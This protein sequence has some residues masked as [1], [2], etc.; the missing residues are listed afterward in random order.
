MSDA[1]THALSGAQACWEGMRDAGLAAVVVCPGARS[2]PLAVAAVASVGLP[3]FVHADERAAAFFALGASRAAG[4]P[5]ALVTTSGS[6]VAHAMPALVE[7]DAQGVPLLLVSAD[8]PERLQGCGAPQ[9]MRQQG[10][11]S[12][13]LRAEAHLSVGQVDAA[14]SC[15]LRTRA[16]Q[17]A[18]MACAVPRRGP[19]HLNVSFDEPLLPPLVGSPPSAPVTAPASAWQRVGASTALDPMGLAAW[20]TLTEASRRP[21]VVLGPL[22]LQPEERAFAEAALDAGLAV[23][24]DPASELRGH[25]EALT[26]GDHVAAAS[27]AWRRNAP[28]LVVRCGGTLTSKALE[29]AIGAADCPV[30]ALDPSQRFTDPHRRPMT[31]FG[32]VPP[33]A[34]L[35]GW[36]VDE[37]Y[38]EG[39][40]ACDALVRALIAA[41]PAQGLLPEEAAWTL[42]WLQA[43]CPQ[44]IQV[45]SSM[46]I[47]W[48]ELLG[49]P[50]G[51]HV[52]V[53]SNRGLNGIDGTLASA[54]GWAWRD[55]KTTWVLL[56]DLAFLHDVGS[57]ELGR[58]C[59]GRLRVFVLNNDGGGIFHHLPFHGSSATFEAVFGTPHGLQAGPIAQ[60]FG[61]HAETVT[62]R[63]DMEAVCRRLE[64]LPGPALIEVRVA[65]DPEPGATRAWRSVVSRALEQWSTDG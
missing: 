31:F 11:F 16:A 35:V 65:R 27:Q 3:V 40:R 37:A 14:A 46:P 59:G 7:A 20:R 13:F 29:R 18:H 19:A 50:Q 39:W 64:A 45:A 56:G 15:Y 23:L 30:V 21:L 5:V 52:Q 33:P 8:R 54:A 48:L 34:A 53:R 24:T 17:V 1:S 51:G 6:A 26:C 28:D 22:P 43:A 62:R 36:Q 38:R 12:A 9:T 58:R 60:A 41:P 57:L 55:A 2:G 44:R 32:A 61:W 63:E 49:L 42:A 25:P 4:A 10:I 47:R